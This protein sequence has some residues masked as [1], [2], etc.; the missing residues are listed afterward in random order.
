MRQAWCLDPPT[1]TIEPMVFLVDG[2]GVEVANLPPGVTAALSNDTLI[3]S[4]TIT[5]E[6]LYNP[7]ITTNEGCV[8]TYLMLDMSLIVDP[9]FSC[10]VEGESVIL[11]W[12]GMNALLEW[13]GEI[14]L[15]C[16]TADGFIDTRT[17]FLPFQDSVVWEGLPT[18]TELAFGMTGTGDPYCFPGYYETMCMITTSAVIDHEGEDFQVRVMTESD[19]LQLSASD[20]LS[21][22][23]IY[24]MQGSLVATQRLNARTATVPIASLAP[25]AFMLRVTR[26]DGRVSTQRFIKEQ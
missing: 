13:G 6:G 10:T 12:P 11:H 26:A 5:N 18:N 20:M 15:L 8:S 1:V 22:V 23:Y 17:Y 21:E 9:Q 3:I 7:E 16:T 24:N 2:T 25:A 19:L 4:G 14:I